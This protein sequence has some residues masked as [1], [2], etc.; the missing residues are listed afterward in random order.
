MRTALLS[1][2]LVFALTSHSQVLINE[3]CATNGDVRIDTDFGNFS[4]WLELYNPSTTSKNVS[5]FF[6]SNDPAQPFKWQIPS[7][8]SIPSKG[9]LIIW[10]DEQWTGLHAG[11]DLDADGGSIMLSNSTGVQ[12]DRVDFPLQYTNVSYGRTTDGASAWKYSSNPTP[13]GSNSNNLEGLPLALP[14]FSKA[15]GRYTGTVSISLAH[16]TAGVDIRFTTNGSE[17]TQ[18][19][20]K[21][22]SAI[23]IS[24]T[25]IIKAKAFRASHLPSET[26]VATYLINEHAANLPVI[27]I[28][29]KPEYLWD[30]TIGIYTDGTN[31]VPGNCNNNNMNWNRDWDRHATFEYY[32]ASGERQVGQHVDIRIGGACS[33]N[34]PQKSFVINPKTK[35]GDNDFDYA[36]F[37]TKPDVDKFGELFLRNAGND[38]NT[39]M[40]RDAFLQSL[41]I[42]QMDLDYMAY[43]PTVFYLNGEYWGIQNLREKIDGNYIESNYNIDREDVDLLETWENAIEGDNSAWVTYK[44]TLATLNPNDP[45][46]FD[47]IDSHI[48]VQ[49]YINYLVTEIYVANTDWPGNNVKFW[50]QRSTNGKFRWILWDTDF[51]FGLYTDQSYPTHPTLNFAT[52]T[53]GPGWPNPPASTL[54]IRLV[55]QN[56]EFRSRFI[57]TLATAMG[58]TFHPDRINQK[59]DEFKARIAAEVPYHKQR[60]WGNVGDWEY[61]IQRMRDFSA[62]RHPFM[63]AHAAA[64][65]GV[66]PLKFSVNTS[67]ANAGSV[68]L[69]GVTAQAFT[70]APFYSSIPYQIDAKPNAGFRFTGWSVTTRESETIVLS[71]LGSAWR[72]FDQGSLPAANWTST[73]FDDASWSQG[74]AQLGYGDGDETTVVNFGPDANNKFITT[75]FRKNFNLTDTVGVTSITASALFDDGV[76]VYLNGIEVYRNNMPTGTVD[77]NTLASSAITENTY[78]SFSVPKGILKPGANTWG[79]EVHQNSGSSSDVSFD[80]QASVSRYGEEESYELTDLTVQDTAYA[81]VSMTAYFEP[82]ASIE[83]LV[84]NEISAAKSFAK[85]N[86]GETE[87]WI[88]LYNASAQSI[89]IAGLMLTDDL[90]RMDKHIIDTEVPW[91]LQPGQYQI[92][93]AD[94]QPEQG[95]DHL[96]FKLSADGESVGIYHAAGF[97]LNVIAEVDFE[98]MPEGF[99]FARLPNATGPFAF[100]SLLTPGAANVE[101][102]EPE[103]GFWMYPNPTTQQLNINT[104][105]ENTTVVIFD[106]MGQLVS[107]FT[108]TTA[109]KA[110]LDISHLADGVYLVKIISALGEK[111]SRLIV[112]SH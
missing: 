42:G 33:R 9:Y 12:V 97:D 56:P 41:G 39:T 14:I 23:S 54:H 34:M 43:Q 47:F 71:P 6:L 100:T 46:T 105:E 86:A 94:G 80:F 103:T 104:P 106:M 68:K 35:Y 44:N 22:T 92:L 87:D 75:Y 95:R 2:F 62:Q 107:Q 52:E 67:P 15:G 24:A 82:I 112:S 59:L 30:N 90:A 99:S 96:N 37:P 70:D 101:G 1:L 88:E 77:Y 5:G 63:Q 20:T 98:A 53:N 73:T 72:Y 36:F 85:D 89:N 13:S 49:E 111:K 7:N 4:P 69:N 32:S 21:Y 79:I 55:L 16:P 45:A 108:I 26:A 51:G 83:G 18:S 50:R 10:C 19:S 58:T 65:F 109:Q 61:E 48:D 57:A 78:F 110:S 64:F 11:F 31:G 40:F 66:S 91:I 81:D 93:W 25:R 38:F 17:P 84:L 28:S 3:V 27:S 60:W 74:N 76:V 29:T 8:T 102:E